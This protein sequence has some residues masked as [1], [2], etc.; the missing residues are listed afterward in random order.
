MACRYVDGERLSA[1]DE[2]EVIGKLLRYHPHSEDKIG[3]GLDYIMV[4][5]TY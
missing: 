5:E 4:S 3:R 1:K 2:K